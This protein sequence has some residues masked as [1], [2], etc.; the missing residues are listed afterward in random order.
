MVAGISIACALAAG[1]LSIV[2]PSKYEASAS[3]TVSDPSDNVPAAA[4]MAVVNDLAQSRI[5][6]YSARDSEIQ[7]SAEIGTGTTAQTLTLTIEGPEELEC[8]EL[9]NAI[10][11]DVAENAKAVFETLQEANEAGLADLAA[12]NTSEDVASVLSGSLLQ[13]IL[14]SDRTFAFCS[15][16]VGDAVEAEKAGFGLA[17]L[18]LVGF[19]GGLF[20]AAI[21]VVAINAIKTPIKS[22]EELEAAANLPVFC[23]ETPSGLGEKLWANIQFAVDGE[24]D[25]VCLVPLEGSSAKVCARGLQTAI[26]GLGGS[27]TVNDFAS[28]SILAVDSDSD[29]LSIYR[30]DPLSVSIGAAYCAHNATA[31]VICAYAW[32]D[33]LRTLECVMNE[34][35]WAKARIAGVALLECQKE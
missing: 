18:T 15:F 30:C 8:V 6:S 9:A 21:V 4:M 23:S 13:D 16:L 2:L 3:I 7:A 11:S 33:S 12:L 32:S 35:A 29:I 24:I 1:L 27:V 28:D 31:T 20:L 10:A 19:G 22:R 14:G 5:A 34:L 25:S 26:T 17:T